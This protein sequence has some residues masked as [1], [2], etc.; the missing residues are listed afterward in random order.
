M[1]DHFNCSSRGPDADPRE[2]QPPRIILANDETAVSSEITYRSLDSI[3]RNRLTASLDSLRI[4]LYGGTSNPKVF[5]GPRGYC[6]YDLSGTFGYESDPRGDS[7]RDSFAAIQTGTSRSG[8][9][10]PLTTRSSV[11][12]N[13]PFEASPNGLFYT[14][15]AIAGVP[16]REAPHG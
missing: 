9:F 15:E 10:P 4:V 14:S 1:E 2:K 6:Q 16:V 11:E 3:S 5:Y 13:T 12:Q 7:L 8:S